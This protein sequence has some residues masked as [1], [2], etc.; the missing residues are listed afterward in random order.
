VWRRFFFLNKREYYICEARDGKSFTMVPPPFSFLWHGRLRGWAAPDSSTDSPQSPRLPQQIDAFHV[1]GSFVFSPLL[2]F[3]DPSPSKILSPVKPFYKIANET[4][5]RLLEAYNG[6]FLSAFFPYTR[7]KS[8]GARPPSELSVTELLGF[9]RTDNIYS[10]AYGPSYV[11][12][13]YFLAELG[14]KDLRDHPQNS[15]SNRAGSQ[16][17]VL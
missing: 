10:R 6:R 14:R 11:F 8:L 2:L 12:F 9:H 13:P 5:V 3:G 7:P 4:F 15:G 1:D 17:E 16:P